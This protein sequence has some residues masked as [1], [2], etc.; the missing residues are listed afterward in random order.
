[1]LHEKRHK[2]LARQLGNFKR[3]SRH[4][5]RCVRICA[6]CSMRYTPKPCGAHNVRQ[7]TPKIWLAGVATALPLVLTY[8]GPSLERALDHVRERSPRRCRIV[9][10]HDDIGVRA[11]AWSNKPRRRVASRAPAHGSNNVI[12]FKAMGRFGVCVFS[13]RK[14]LKCEE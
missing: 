6:E 8:E 10:S 9:T 14:H 11:G 1:M 4:L 2:L 5:M 13:S 7:S 3:R 12:L